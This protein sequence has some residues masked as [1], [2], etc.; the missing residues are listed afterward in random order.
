MNTLLPCCLWC[1][2]ERNIPYEIS[3]DPTEFLIKRLELRPS[4][5]ER[6]FIVVFSRTERMVK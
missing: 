4:A 5:V 1:T 2:I 3:Y 6:Q